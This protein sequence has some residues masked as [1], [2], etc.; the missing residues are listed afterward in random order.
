MKTVTLDKLDRIVIP[1]Q[2]CKELNMQAGSPVV[3]TLENDSVV[4]RPEKITCKHC[5]CFMES[6]PKFQICKDCIEEIKKLYL[7]TNNL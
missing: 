5:G 2:F 3:I 4:I 6:Y 1:K 7:E